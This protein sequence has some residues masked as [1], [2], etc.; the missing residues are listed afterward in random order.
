MEPQDI[1]LIPPTVPPR[2]RYARL[3]ILLVVAAVLLGLLAALFMRRPVPKPKAVP[4]QSV[5]QHAPVVR[6]AL[7][8]T[9]LQAPTGIVVTPDKADKRLFVLE[10]A[11]TV[12]I[13]NSSGA[14]DQPSFLDIRDKVMYSGEMGL[15]GLA[16]DPAYKQNGYFYV[17]YID[18]GQNTV[19]ARY[20]VSAQ[21]NV[22]DPAS[23]KVLLTVKQPYPNHKGGDI[24][25]G[26]DGYLYIPLGDGGSGG[27]PENRAQ[28]KSNYL[29]KILRID[30]H[31]GDP[32]SVPA[33]NPFAKEAGT[34]P[35]IWA[36][37][38]R[39]PW[40]ISFDAATGDM[41]V[42]DVG[43][44][45]YEEIDVQKAS[46]K[47]GENYGWRCYEALHA[48]KTDG[49]QAQGSYTA[50]VLEYDHQQNR[51][52]ITGGYVY[53]GSRY[54]ALVGK[55]FYGDYCSGQLFYA[56]QS[57]GKYAPVLAAQTPY[58]FSAFGQSGDGE[59]YFAD[60]KTGSIYHLE[61]AANG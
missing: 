40:R 56:A 6:S 11:G 25:F 42:A 1:Q 45:L 23:E 27:D 14:L 35:E 20:K 18:K 52:S 28:D 30:V 51:C 49:C 39:N 33:T 7:V 21:S 50:P 15:L 19:V 4:V 2:P 26:P 53:R 46:S 34:K 5:S 48:F 32:Y 22:A 55:Y 13:L 24:T 16:F 61:D 41:Y 44:G 29:G 17:D 10:E 36:Y 43:Q 57:Q 37:G 47:G 31:K 3:I 60:Y 8:A 59:L 9:G 54:S 12:R 38:L 58:M